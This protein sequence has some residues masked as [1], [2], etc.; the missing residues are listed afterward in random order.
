MGVLQRNGH[1]AE[2]SRFLQRVQRIHALRQLIKFL[3]FRFG[4]GIPV[5]AIDRLEHFRIRFCRLL[6]LLDSLIDR[7][8][9]GLH[10]SERL[11]QCA[12]TIVGLFR[13]LQFV[14]I[15]IN[16]LPEFFQ[17]RTGLGHIDRGCGRSLSA[18]FHW[19]HCSSDPLLCHAVR[20]MVGIPES[21]ANGFHVI[22]GRGQ[23]VR[24]GPERFLVFGML[25]ELLLKLRGGGA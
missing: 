10:V 8:R 24:L 17:L 9:R 11:R 16:G 13:R 5:H 15:A 1:V 3:A 19:P 6:G 12:E 2:R 7:V 21:C 20:F 18:G 4:Q 22:H 23:F 25:F 14:G